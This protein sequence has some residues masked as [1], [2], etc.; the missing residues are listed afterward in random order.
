MVKVNKVPCITI[1]NI[2]NA[3]QKMQKKGHREYWRLDK[4]FCKYMTPA[5]QEEF[6]VNIH[7]VLNNKKKMKAIFDRALGRV[8]NQNLD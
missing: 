3:A 5:K 4:E 8:A 1:E 7:K 2:R 6:R